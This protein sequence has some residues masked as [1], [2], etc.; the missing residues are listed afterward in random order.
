[1]TTLQVTLG[2]RCSFPK[3]ASDLKNTY[4]CQINEDSSDSDEIETEYLPENVT[5]LEYNGVWGGRVDFTNSEFPICDNF[6]NLIEISINKVKSIGNVFDNCG[7]VRNIKIITSVFKEIPE[8]LFSKNL[9]LREIVLFHNKI[10]TLSEKT[11]TG[12]KELKTINLGTN[13]ITML[14]PHIF[15]S[16]PNLE[17]LI[18]TDNK[19]QNLEHDWFDGLIKLRGL[20]LGYNEI[21]DLPKNIFSTLVN[22]N[23]LDVNHNNLKIIHSDSF[24]KHEQLY[25]FNMEDNKINAID[26]KLFD[27]TALENSIYLYM[28]NNLCLNKTLDNEEEKSLK[29]EFVTC[30]ANYQP[31]EE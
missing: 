25:S 28:Q 27:K 7:E 9:N 30:F 26:E 20:S 2:F 21:S 19:I 22:L 12:L 14:P 11:F 15:K 5:E 18:L 24:G 3:F 13:E 16:L 23:D 17:H 8:N 31:R 29:H 4:F 1:M 10:T 6:P